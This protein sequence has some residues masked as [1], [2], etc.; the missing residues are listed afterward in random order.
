MKFGRECQQLQGVSSNSSGS[1]QDVNRQ[2]S[3]KLVI[4]VEQIDFYFLL[5]ITRERRAT[6]P[7]A[8]EEP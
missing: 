7:N 6:I 1:E 4:V 5:L 8:S 3:C 2:P